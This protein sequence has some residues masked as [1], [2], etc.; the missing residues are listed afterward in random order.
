[1]LSNVSTT[2]LTSSS[3]ME[4]TQVQK[5]IKYV[6]QLYRNVEFVQRFVEKINSIKFRY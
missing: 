5:Y 2:L 1:M 4:I 6:S 3:Q